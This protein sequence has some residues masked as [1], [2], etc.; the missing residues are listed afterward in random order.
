MSAKYNGFDHLTFYVG[1]ALQAA[2]WYVARFG[3]TPVAYR[4]LETGSRETVAHVIKQND[5]IFSFVSVLNPSDTLDSG[6]QKDINKHGDLVKD[7]AFNV[8]DAR[9]LYQKAVERGAK[10]VQE[11]KEF[12]DEN[13]TVITATIQTYGDCTHTFV[14]RGGYKGIFL[15]GYRKTDDDDPLSRITPAVGLQF[16]DHVVGNQANDQMVPIVEW[17]E[18]ML[19]FHRFWSVDDKMIHTEYSSLRSIVVTDVDEKIKMPINEPANGKRKSQ[20]QE[21]ID[22]HGDAGVQ[23]VAL[24][25]N[26]IITSVTHLQARGLKFLRAPKSYYDT[27]REKLAVSPIKVKEDL[28]VL[29]KLN[30][31]I[32]YDDKG[33]LLQIFT[34]PIEYRPTLFFENIQINN[35]QEFGAENFKTLFEG[36]ERDQA[37]RGNLTPYGKQ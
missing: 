2:G 5:I 24:N 35:H 31:L 3:F 36:I 27:L 13:G 8:T 26:D 29:E 7:V 12:T 11:P 34:K 17:Y 30:I 16:I 21:Y 23:H 6:L 28:D 32:D 20:I 33:Y 19:G 18:K 10:S 14:Q 22:Y 15:P 37:E 4:G 1:N 9:T 25:T